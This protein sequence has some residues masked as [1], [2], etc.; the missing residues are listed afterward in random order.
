MK[1]EAAKDVLSQM[2][3]LIWGNTL[4]RW[5]LAIAV[6][7]GII[8]VW[9]VL[10][11]FL[12]RKLERLS[13]STKNE[14]DDVIFGLLESVHPFL[15]YVVSLYISCRFITLPERSGPI[16]H[17]ILVISILLQIGIW[18]ASI[19]AILLRNYLQREDESSAPGQPRRKCCSR[20]SGGGQRQRP[21]ACQ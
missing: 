15:C 1:K 20:Q 21:L 4:S 18:G 19:S 14:I 11:G 7:V 12:M 6:F 16:L 13:A 5:S 17:G 3:I 8:L 2:D 9:R 10:K